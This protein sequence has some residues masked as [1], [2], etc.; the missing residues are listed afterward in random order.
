MVNFFA[1]N[2]Y[3]PIGLELGSRAVQMMQFTADRKRLIEAVRWDLPRAT[4]DETA[5]SRSRSLVEAIEQARQGRAFRGRNVVVCLNS[6]ELFVQNVRV[7]KGPSSELDR[8]VQ[9]EA[10][11]R[12]P[13]PSAEADLHYLSAGDIRQ[14]DQIRREV[15]LLACHRPVVDRLLSVVD[16]AGFRA[17]AVEAEPSALLRAY[18]RQYRRDHDKTQRMMFVRLGTF[19]TTVVIAQGTEVFF[20]K[21]ID[22]GGN[23][24][25]E[26]VAAH[27][28][29]SL[30]EA[31]ILRRNNGERRSDQQ[32][33]EIAAG[34]AQATRDVI[35]RLVSELALCT[36]YHSVAFRGQ[37]INCL[38][39]GGADATESMVEILGERLDV[40][41][42]L[43]DP[44][45]SFEPPVPPQH[46]QWDVVAGLA[47]RDCN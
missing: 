18:L 23:Q 20:V 35:E 40:K 21:Y 22:V 8:M 28:A 14:G 30:E 31:A 10:A 19:N 47:L 45:R 16:D 13:F 41:C 46:A 12:L 3:G 27:L 33:P 24:L 29:T 43:G 1:K 36:R 42:E 5:E 2:A 11:S 25:D 9:Q 38:V 15:I 7:P 26:A 6:R 37:T 32:D 39:L 4:G 44:L 17:V 34:V